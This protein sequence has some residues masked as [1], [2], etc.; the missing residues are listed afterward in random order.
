[1]ITINGVNYYTAKELIIKNNEDI[2]AIN[3]NIETLEEEVKSATSLNIINLT[4][5]G[6][7]YSFPDTSYTILVDLASFEKSRLVLNDEYIFKPFMFME[8]N[9]EITFKFESA[10]FDYTVDIL[11]SKT[12]ATYTAS[13]TTS[14]LGD[15]KTSFDELEEKVST[16]TSD[17][18]DEVT[19]AVDEEDALKETINDE[20]SR[21]KEAEEDLQTNI[22]N[23]ASTRTANDTA[24]QTQI[25]LKQNITTAWNKDNL[26]I[27][28]EDGVLT[29][30]TT[31]A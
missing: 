7:T 15:L 11:Y 21:A 13:T 23:E 31:E 22:D 16:N 1:M 4:E 6:T 14:D 19:R 12:N 3:S 2:Q 28:Y 10:N 5:S 29:I 24:L 17:I 25:D 26:T 9:T 20:V 27:T 8:T 18:T 30:T